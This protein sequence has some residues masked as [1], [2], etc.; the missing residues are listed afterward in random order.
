MNDEVVLFVCTIT[1]LRLSITN[2]NHEDW[3][4]YYI[5]FIDSFG[6]GHIFNIVKPYP[7]FLLPYLNS[8]VFFCIAP[9]AFGYGDIILINGLRQI[10]GI[11]DFFK[12]KTI[13]QTVFMLSFYLSIYFSY[14]NDFWW[15]N[16]FPKAWVGRS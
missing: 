14:I 5:E 6:Y 12:E 16:S 8:D 1:E 15:Y 2:G 9:W 4:C 10:N 11:I 13:R 7:F 3:L